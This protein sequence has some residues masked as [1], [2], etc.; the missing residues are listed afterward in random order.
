MSL[1]V[2]MKSGHFWS[3]RLEIFTKNSR[4]ILEKKNLKK[5]LEFYFKNAK[6]TQKRKKCRKNI[7]T[8]PGRPG[9]SSIGGDLNQL[10]WSNQLLNS[11]AL[12][13][14]T[15]PPP[16]RLDGEKLI[17]KKLLEFSVAHK[18]KV[19]DQVGAN[20][21]LK[22]NKFLC[23]FYLNIC[24]VF[25][26][27]KYFFYPIYKTMLT[28]FLKKWGMPCGGHYV[29]EKCLCCPKSRFWWDGNMPVYW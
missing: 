7:K 28:P 2:L 20:Q 25:K 29:T 23:H 15:P 9:I 8:R 6:K 27:L 11:T 4:K 3:W 21:V 26:L 17:I 18:N 5:I 14:H 16:A 10:T 12:C 19:F 24:I 22:I 1:Q 13:K